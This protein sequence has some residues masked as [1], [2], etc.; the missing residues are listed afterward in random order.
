MWLPPGTPTCG[1]LGR[2]QARL[3][4][5][6]GKPLQTAGVP[7]QPCPRGGTRR[8]K[9]G[10]LLPEKGTKPAKERARRD[11]ACRAPGRL[12][13]WLLWSELEGW[14]SSGGPGGA[15]TMQGGVSA[16]LSLGGGAGTGTPRTTAHVYQ[17]CTRPVL[18]ITVAVPS[19]RLSLHACVR[20][21]FCESQ[22][23][24]GRRRPTGRLPSS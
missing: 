5:H 2:Q 8:R 23:L 11:R 6:G 24:S 20:Q 19:V 21:L 14:S 18:S 17:P 12:P 1:D 15:E 7:A 4:R 10:G 9:E 13:A 3:S 16:A 22:Q